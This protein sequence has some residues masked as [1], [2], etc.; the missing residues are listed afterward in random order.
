MLFNDMIHKIVINLF[1][2]SI[3]LIYSYF[4]HHQNYYVN[5]HIIYFQKK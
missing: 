2:I 1:C 5:L 4:I 3:S